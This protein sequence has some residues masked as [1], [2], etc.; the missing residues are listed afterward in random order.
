MPATFTFAILEVAPKTFA[1]IKKRL[2]ATGT[3]PEYLQ[4]DDDHGWLI[5]FGT[6][7]LAVKKRKK[8]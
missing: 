2:R 1:D 7:A 4:K 3:L 8:K 5:V 6:T